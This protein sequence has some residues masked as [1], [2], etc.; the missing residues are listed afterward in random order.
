MHLNSI[1]GELCLP[2]LDIIGILKKKKKCSPGFITYE[3]HTDDDEFRG[4]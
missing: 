2:T 3:M 1:S 4:F